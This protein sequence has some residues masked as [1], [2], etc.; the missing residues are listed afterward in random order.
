MKLSREFNFDAAHTLDHY[1]QGHPNTRVHGHSFRA[2]ITVEGLP[3]ANGQIVDLE[4]VGILLNAARGQLDHAMLNDI[5]GL[6]KPTLE[7]I[8]L[9][10]WGELQQDLPQLCAVEVFR[11]SLGHS[12]LYKGSQHGH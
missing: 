9:W 1:P 6:E 10:L 11:D 5:K 4:R 7:N 8:C 3:D 2:R 12:C